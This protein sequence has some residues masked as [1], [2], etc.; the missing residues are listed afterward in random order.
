MAKARLSAGNSLPDPWLLSVKAAINYSASN[1]TKLLPSCLPLVND[2]GPPN[3][4]QGMDF[5][6]DKVDHAE[7]LRISMLNGGR[8]VELFD[9]VNRAS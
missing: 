3:T 5:P 7:L 1:G 6:E 9:G 4:E 8:S 2:D